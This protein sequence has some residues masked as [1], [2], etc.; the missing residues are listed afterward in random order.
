M[1]RDQAI[2]ACSNGLLHV[3]TRT[4][5]D[6]TPGFFNRVAVHDE[7]PGGDPEPTVEARDHA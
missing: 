3:P 5:L 2:V 6:L 1:V 4:L 7:Q